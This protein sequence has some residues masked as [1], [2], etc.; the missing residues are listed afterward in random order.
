VPAAA[1][2]GIHDLR[3]R[4]HPAITMITS[5]PQSYRIAH[6]HN[7]TCYTNLRVN[8]KERRWKPGT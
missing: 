8:W 7:F 4:R 2:K 3:R 1:L 6:Y 5:L